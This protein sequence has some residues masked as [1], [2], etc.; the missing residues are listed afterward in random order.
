[1]KTQFKLLLLLLGMLIYTSGCAIA[2]LSNLYTARSQGRGG[3]EIGLGAVTT[4]SGGGFVPAV[5]FDYGILDN[6]DLGFKYE[7][8]DVGINAKY[9]FINGKTGPSLALAASYGS[10]TG[11]S[12]WYVGP[13]FSIKAGFF[14]PY[15]SARY[16]QV[17][18]NSTTVTSGSFTVVAP[19]T[20]ITYMHYTAGAV[21]WVADFMGLDLE[22][23]TL[24]TLQNGVNFSTGGFAAIALIFK[25]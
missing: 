3:V 14:E 6:L 22:Y 23:N 12:Y 2:P 25:L 17:Y 20:N 24:G 1:M 21:L 19:T 9:A 8:L 16:N 10:T 5:K 7:T 11:G 15:I 18:W 13:V 4:T